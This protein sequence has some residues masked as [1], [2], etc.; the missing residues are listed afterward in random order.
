MKVFVGLGNPGREYDG[1]RHNIGFAVVDLLE[2]KLERSSGW[3]AGKS[4]YYVAKGLIA[5]EEV[6]L[7]KPT[8]YMNLS[9]R[10]VRDA[11][12]FYKCEI[13]DLVVI[14][15]DIAL[16]TGTLRLRLRGSDGGHNGLSSVI[17]EL[18]TEEFIRLRL[19]VGS[20][21]AKGEQV[22]YVLSRFKE[23]DRKAV[24]EMI[25]KAVDGCELI[26]KS[27]AAKAMNSL[28]A[29]IVEENGD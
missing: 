1:T 23:S 19:G 15:D 7:V 21:F 20:D 26:V 11:L 18:G 10:A 16:P 13:A 2:T 6:L 3:R 14:A 27:G 8:T 28:N 17:Y 29:K 9:G 4:D 5:A 24:D 25:E 22:R 12:A